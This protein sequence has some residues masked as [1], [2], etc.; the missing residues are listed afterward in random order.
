M[1]PAEAGEQQ[2]SGRQEAGRTAAFTVAGRAWPETPSPRCD[3]DL[4][5]NAKDV[6]ALVS[7]PADSEWAQTCV[8]PGRARVAA[9]LNRTHAPTCA[10]ERGPTREESGR[11]GECLPRGNGLTGCVFAHWVS[12]S[13][14]RE[15]L[16]VSSTVN[17]YQPGAWAAPSVVGSPPCRAPCS[18]GSLPG[19]W[20]PL[21][22]S[23][24]S[25]MLTVSLSPS[26][27]NQLIF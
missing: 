13:R 7:V 25:Y 21:S 8:C 19:D 15:Q 22:L 23:V 17:G 20:L 12:V 1:E 27:I 9:G 11:C 3:R 2:E 16:A 4:E 26:D 6:S 18:V 24:P 14:L 5:G 10:P